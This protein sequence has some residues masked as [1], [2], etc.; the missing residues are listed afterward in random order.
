MFKQ[1]DLY[2]P[3][4]MIS[5]ANNMKLLL[6]LKVESQVILQILVAKG[7]ITREEVQSM[8]EKVK[9]QP[10]YRASYELLEKSANMAEYY[11]EHPEEHLK[12]LMAAKMKGQL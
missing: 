4:S 9:S 11:K 10:Q 1:D 8:R 2:H 3:D 7:I 5:E 6:D 12:D